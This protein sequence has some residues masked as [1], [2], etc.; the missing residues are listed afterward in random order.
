M[1]QA[2]VLVTLA[3]FGAAFVSPAHA[4]KYPEPSIYPI[5]WQLD[6]KHSEPKR[7]VVGTTPYWYM[8]YTV[9]NNTGQE[10]VW[11]PNFVMLTND[12]KNIPSDRDIPIEVFDQIKASENN[13]FLQPAALVAGPLRQGPDQAKDG[14]AIWKEP[15]PRMG[16]FKIFVGSLSGEFV[17]LKDDKDKP[18]EGPDKLPVILRKTLELDYAV[19]GDQY[20]PARHEVHA[21]GEKWVM[22]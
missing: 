1:R 12:G 8:T 6:F 3:A 19:Y 4:K 13:R 7:V 2:L 20:Y 17:I 15:N 9:T 22:R 21:T 11:R 18:V 16:E 14:V 5:A 10:Q